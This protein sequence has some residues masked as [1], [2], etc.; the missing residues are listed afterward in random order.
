MIV[1][2]TLRGSHIRAIST[3]FIISWGIVH[4]VS[5]DPKRVVSWTTERNNIVLDWDCPRGEE[6]VPL[7][8]FLLVAFTMALPVAHTWRIL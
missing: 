7:W 3:R 5:G 2:T 6:T 8:F 1:F 4:R